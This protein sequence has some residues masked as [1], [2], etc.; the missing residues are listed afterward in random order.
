M[1]KILFR[2][3]KGFCGPHRSQL[4]VAATDWEIYGMDMQTDRITDLL[5]E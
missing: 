2:G 5:S 1:Q 3:V 4:L